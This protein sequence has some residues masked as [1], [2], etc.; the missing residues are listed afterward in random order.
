MDSKKRA[1]V[2]GAL[3]HD[4]GKVGQRAQR[5]EELSKATLDR[6]SDICPGEG[7]S[8]HLHVLWTDEFF[9]KY[10][11]DE[12][13][14]K[15]IGE[16]TF[17][18]NPQNLASFHHKPASSL[19][20]LIQIADRISSGE[21]EEFERG[22]KDDYIKRR[23]S[24]I[25]NKV[26]L[27]GE[28]NSE[29]YFYNLVQLNRKKDVFPKRKNE[30]DPPYETQEIEKHRE[31]YKAL[32]EG[33]IKDFEELRDK[34][35]RLNLNFDLF[36]NGLYHLLMKYT[37]CVPSYTNAKDEIDNDISLFDHSRTTAAI[38]S[39]LYDLYGEDE[40]PEKSKDHEFLVVEG[41]I[42]GIQKFIYKLA[43][44]SGIKGVGRILRGRS[45]FLTLLPI[46][47]ANYI[48]QNLD[49]TFVNILY[50]GG[51]NFQILLPNKEEAISK[52]RQ[53]GDEIDRWLF[54]TFR[55]EVGLV[56]GYV[57]AN[58]QDLGKGYGEVIHRLK[59]EMENQKSKKFL[60]RFFEEQKFTMRQKDKLCIVCSSL[61]T[62]TKED[63]CHLCNEHRKLGGDIPKCEYL[64]LSDGKNEFLKGTK[65]EFGILGKAWFLEEPVHD[66]EINDT[67]AH[68]QINSTE[69][70]LGFK[71]LGKT[72]PKAKEVIRK[73]ELSGREIEEAQ[74]N[75]GDLISFDHL[76][77][78]AEGD[79]KLGV[80]RMDVD[81]LGLIFS[82]G[83]SKI[84]ND[85]NVAGASISR[86]AMLSRMLDW[87]FTGYL[88]T[89]CETVSDELRQASKESDVRNLRSKVDCHY[90]IVYSGGDDLFIVAPWDEATELALRVRNDLKEFTGNNPDIDISGGLSLV[91]SKFPV[92]RSGELA[93]EEEKK[94]KKERR[95]FSAFGEVDRWKEVEEN[96][97]F[98]KLLE[99]AIHGSNGKKLPRTFLNRMLEIRSNLLGLKEDDP[100]RFLHV[101][102]LVYSITRNIDEKLKISWEG[103]EIWIKERLNKKLVQSK[104]GLERSGFAIKYAL[105]KT[106]R[107]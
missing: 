21:R 70:I 25:F 61:D 71:F 72:V 12:L 77:L 20:R 99:K 97:E 45:M 56:L 27:K 35:I 94:A 91:K 16:V 51:G 1:V 92:S 85:W 76:D 82:L 24:S 4:I 50:A 18:F 68:W 98:G 87:F 22:D 89:L 79:K 49:Q 26:N 2:I 37:W 48:T 105:L 52:L 11:N 106:R 104:E 29:P 75:P 73:D 34:T 33:F 39:C 47:T 36:L 7:Y 5:K 15:V 65:V 54:D 93:G 63:L 95:S 32:W 90:Y 64:V 101:P 10:F 44:P 23:L 43:Q 41:D 69:S 31:K 100:K 30:L 3:L 74:Y 62:E 53:L 28:L 40:L 8:T 103:N 6:E 38:A 19:H 17:D 78:L 86:V 67:Y 84:E 88:N 66:S 81:Y 14:D 46:V 107:R 9:S 42:S 58:R 57:G 13:I 60:R 80:L 59:A 96:L 102:E 55:G 83:L